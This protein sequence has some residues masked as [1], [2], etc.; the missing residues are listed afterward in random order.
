MAKAV[1]LTLT[2]TLRQWRHSQ[3]SGGFAK[4][5]GACPRPWR[6]CKGRGGVAKALGPGQGRG[7]VAKALEAWPRREG[8]LEP[9][10]NPKAVG[11]GQG[12]GGM[13]KA[14]GAWPRA[15]SG[16]QSR[17]GVAKAVG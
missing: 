1:I 2:L 15:W 12:Y 5:V 17:E 11:H 13:A 7:G 6:Q 16:C 9:N 10:P 14:V 3:G 4:A 8:Y